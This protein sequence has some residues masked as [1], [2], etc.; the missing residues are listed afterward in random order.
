MDEQSRIIQLALENRVSEEQIIDYIEKV[1]P[2]RELVR[3]IVEKVASASVMGSSLRVASG[4]LDWVLE[5]CSGNKALLSGV[6]ALML[7]SGAVG[8]YEVKG[9]DTLWRLGGGTNAG[10]QRILAVNP[11]MTADTVLREGMKIVLPSTTKQQPESYE[12]VSG[13]TFSGIARKF[14]L[15]VKQLKELNPRIRDINKIRAGEKVFLKQQQAQ[16][17]Q[18]PKTQTA[19]DPQTNYVARVIYAEAGNSDEEMQ[20]IARLI[21]NRMNS[22]MFPSTAYGVVTQRNQFSCTGGTD[23]NERWAEYSRDL[24]KK[25]QKCYQLAEKVMKGDTSGMKGTDTMVF[26]CTKSLA[27]NGVGKNPESKGLDKEYGHPSSWGDYSTFTPVATSSN[28]VFYSVA[29]K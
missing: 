9:G 4:L 14:G 10:V 15:T 3:E 21:V 7:S 17:K 22:R 8:A 12:V 1:C 24:N 11:G 13:D 19:I 6:L 27:R 20:M 5:K 2:D 18:Q 28:H 25:T 26:Y 29:K 16:P 23:G